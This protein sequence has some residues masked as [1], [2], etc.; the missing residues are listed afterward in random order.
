MQK[1]Q[2]VQSK[3]NGEVYLM[4]SVKNKL[5]PSQVAESNGIES[6]RLSNYQ[7]N[8]N[9]TLKRKWDGSESDNDAKKQVKAK[10][11][12][13]MEY[14]PEKKTL[15]GDEKGSGDEDGTHSVTKKDEKNDA[16][17]YENFEYADDLEIIQNLANTY[18]EDNIFEESDEDAI[19]GRFCYEDGPICPN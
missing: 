6:T 3:I 5:L 16:S 14:F 8:E 9:I 4:P 1:D 12:D 2:N 13:G 19:Q 10:E 7:E 11:I 17:S 15:D 18:C